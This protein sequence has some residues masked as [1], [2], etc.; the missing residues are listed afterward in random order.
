MK[1]GAAGESMP[2]GRHDGLLSLS[3]RLWQNR[4][5]NWRRDM[6]EEP[7]EVRYARLRPSAAVARRQAMPLA[8]LP[9]GV[10]EWH[11]P[12]NPLGLD[13]LKAEAILCHAARRVGGLVMPTLY[14]GDHRRSLAEAL[15]DPAVSDWFPQDAP[16]QTAAIA[17]R[18]QVPRESL[19]READRLD[20]AGGWRVWTEL[21]TNILFLI[22]SLGFERIAAYAGHVPLCKPLDVAAANFARQGGRARFI[23]LDLPGGEDHAALRETSLMLALCPGLA[24]LGE[25]DASGKDHIGIL[26]EDPLGASAEFGWKL[27]DDFAK[28]AKEK[29]AD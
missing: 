27:A 19:S 29:L 20:R 28:A 13:A 24:D 18:M 7:L 6:P 15:F 10:L 16:D 17:Q 14:Y 4:E 5:G 21:A 12:H 26:G 22:E 8:W 23:R 25:L 2:A 1:S 11:G 3:A 9:L